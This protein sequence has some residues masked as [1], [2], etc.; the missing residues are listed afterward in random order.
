M[1]NKLFRVGFVVSH[2]CAKNA[3]GWGTQLF[4]P[5]KIGTTAPSTAL[6]SVQD[7]RLFGSA[8][9]IKNRLSER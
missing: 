6:R 3:H 5:V 9:N 4:E 7:D 8:K 2:P 1:R